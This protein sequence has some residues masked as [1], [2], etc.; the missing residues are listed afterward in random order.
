VRLVDLFCGCGGMTIGLHEAAR[1]AGRKIEIALAIDSDPEVVELYKSNLP[2]AN[3]RAGEVDRIFDGHIGAEPTPAD[4]LISLEVGAAPDILVGG[5]PCQGHSDLNNRT[6]RR[7]PK[8]ALYLL[9]A[10]AAEILK[11]KVVVIENVTG[12]QWDKDGVVQ[13]TQDA[14]TAAGYRV[15][16][17]VLDLRMVGAP[18][19]RRRFVMIGSS[20]EKLDPGALLDDVT[21]AWGEHSDRSVRWAIEDLLQSSADSVFDSAS[22]PTPKNQRRIDFLFDNN[23]YNLPDAERPDCHQDGEHSYVSVYGRLSWSEPTFIRGEA[24][25]RGEPGTRLPVARKRARIGAVC[26]ERDDSSGLLSPAAPS[27]T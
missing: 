16:S 27:I 9:M 14:L 1:R 25:V 11:P 4:R 12:A 23:L 21:S 20:L 15:A 18:Q 6:R 22:A 5:P 8:N 26:A 19:R 7:D 24:L 3:A 17:R 2:K 10:R 13:L